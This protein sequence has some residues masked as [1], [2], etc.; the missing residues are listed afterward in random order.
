MIIY[1]NNK[2]ILYPSV[3]RTMA[4]SCGKPSS[5]SSMNRVT[6]RSPSVPLRRQEVDRRLRMMPELPEQE[7]ASIG[8]PIR[9][10]S[11]IVKFY[12]QIIKSFP[13]I[14]T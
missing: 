5:H 14:T 12:I 3:Q 11:A 8:I 9:K 1:Y 10:F 4:C 13:S 2:K 7:A 6:V